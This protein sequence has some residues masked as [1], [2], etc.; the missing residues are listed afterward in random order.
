[1]LA[2]RLHGSN[3][4]AWANIMREEGELNEKATTKFLNTLRGE[5]E[6]W[7]KRNKVGW[8]GKIS[9]RSG[10]RK[11]LL[12]KATLWGEGKVA[13]VFTGICY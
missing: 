10:H 4:Y 8:V 2:F 1:M 12:G 11:E 9:S 5:T 3:L 6:I 13:M 7:K